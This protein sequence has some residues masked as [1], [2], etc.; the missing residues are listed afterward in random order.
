MLP[1]NGDLTPVGGQVADED[2][3]ESALTG[4]VLS[5]QSDDLACADNEIRTA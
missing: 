5:D 1:R 2:L 4:A 3:H